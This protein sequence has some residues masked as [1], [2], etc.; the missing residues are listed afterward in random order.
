VRVPERQNFTAASW[1]FALQIPRMQSD[2]SQM[3]SLYHRSLKLN[4]PAWLADVVYWTV[5]IK[6]CLRVYATMASRTV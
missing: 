5:L 6:D 3:M 2:T 4:G 1:R